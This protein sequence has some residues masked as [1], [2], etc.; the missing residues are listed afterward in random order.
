MTEALEA[1][2]LVKISPQGI[3][4]YILI[5]VAD[6]DSIKTV[7]RGFDDCEWHADIFEREETIFM[8]SKLK[9]EC[10][11]GGRIEHDPEKKYM[12]VYGYSQGFGKADHSQSKRILE[13]KYPDYK[14]EISDDGY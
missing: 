9:A 5:N 6:G 3:F 14:I 12:K 8:A 1:V 11:G 13:T 10:I 7:V 4:K 2:P